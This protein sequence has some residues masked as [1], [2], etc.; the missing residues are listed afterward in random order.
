MKSISSADEGPAREDAAATSSR[1]A[2]ATGSGDAEAAR[3]ARRADPA[4]GKARSHR[5]LTAA[6]RQS[7]RELGI[8]LALLNRQVGARLELRE[9]DIACLDLI[10]RLG[11]L[12]P[13]ALAT[14]SGLHP[15]TL[16][17]VLD[18]LERGGWIARDRDSS[19]RRGVRI[20]A[21]RDRH[22]DLL[23]LYAPMNSALQQICSGY[24]ESE[25]ELIAGF[26]RRSS[27]AGHN[28][29]GE[30]ASPGESVSRP[31]RSGRP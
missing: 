26:L 14:G 22:G 13:S 25:L 6:V 12:S 4:G 18:R 29:A 3:A 5:Q 9:A 8:Q 19:D 15:A 21:L 20:R 24:S 30:L 31:D 17:G 23:G 28:A 11:P 16:T 7:L 2:A 10:D 27:D 1:D